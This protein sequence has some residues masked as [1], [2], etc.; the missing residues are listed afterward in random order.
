MGDDRWSRIA[1]HFH[2]AA[3]LPPAEQPA[4]L[5]S[6]CAGDQ[7]LRRE[8]ESLLAA[9]ATKAAIEGAAVAPAAEH[10]AQ[11]D[12]E[13]D[14]IGKRIDRYLI[15]GLIGK[16]G[17]GA[18]YRAVREDEFR[19]E[20]ALKL[21]KRGTD[22]EAA[23]GRFRTERQIL[24]GLNHPNITKLLD[25]GT[26]PD[27]RPYFV[28][29][30]VEGQPITNYC[31]THQLSTPERLELFRTVCAAVQYA[32]RNLVVHRDLKPANILVTSEG[33]PKLLDFG[34]A[35]I[36]HIEPAEATLDMTIPA[37]R[38][39]TPEYASPEQV[40]GEPIT[41][42][43]D[44]Y[45]LGIL[46]YE[47]LT[48]QR[49]HRLKTRTPEEFAAVI[50]ND[51]PERPSAVATRG[52]EPGLGQQL[53]KQLRGDLDNIV[54]KALQKD[55]RRRYSSVEQMEEDIRRHLEGLPVIARKDT[56][57]YRTGKFIRR[58]KLG[59]AAVTTVVAM[60]AI[61]AI[62]MTVQAR[63]IAEERN[64]ANREAEAARQVSDFLVGLFEVS[65][66]GQARGSTIT[67]RELLDRGAKKIERDLNTQPLT[68]ARMKYTVGKVLLNLGLY[69]EAAELLEGAVQIQCT[70]LGDND[71]ALMESLDRLATTY[72]E[73]GEY[74]KAEPLFRRALAIAEKIRGPEH[75]ETGSVLSNLGALGVLRNNYA[76][77]EPLLK[78][79]LEIQ[80][81]KYGP[82]HRDVADT[83]TN[84][85]VLC[86]RM[87]RQ[88]EATD[89]Y[90][91]VLALRE[92]VL[93]P[94]HPDIAQALNNLGVALWRQGQYTEAAPVLERSLALFQKVLG[95]EH[96]QVGR[97]MA[98][99][100]TLYTDQGQ[101]AKAET[102]Y[103]RSL[104]IREKALGPAHPDVAHSLNRLGRLRGKQGKYREAV[105]LY[106]R[107]LA[108]Y[109]KALGPDSMESAITRTNLANL[110]RD[111]AKYAAAEPLY[112]RALASMEKTFGPNNTNVALVL[113][114]FAQ[115]LR[116]A[117][118]AREAEPV[119]ARAKAIRETA[120]GSG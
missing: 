109:D 52:K 63:R 115:M 70:R 117:R 10:L 26:S 72:Q 42:S 51:E 19:M 49:P 14:L 57:A 97:L 5:D 20:V 2:Q 111:H 45:S 25:G 69:R 104:E 78:R 22:T 16:G 116:K 6:A 48:G 60:L 119:E 38:V 76:E 13:T 54:L 61:F 81:K 101:L 62:G 11:A 43:T 93:A 31:Q 112:R 102:L 9:D 92:K 107:A 47:L 100:A 84:L 88:K 37:M 35:K 73:Q 64:R 106:E 118:R 114:D 28:M 82:D 32:H 105:G 74:A 110:H 39:M 65:D 41:T 87:G 90:R 34:I 71:A 83:L 80:R 1:D 23:L 77:A 68:Q 89:Y 3:H 27:H 94:D 24:A 36:L 75:E 56:A 99:L 103:L 40:R 21:L 18:V 50:C 79:A 58:H 44:V 46:L 66:P 96:S 86:E 17:M 120:K 113:G 30:F 85:A 67:A 29:E 33:V 98:N 12:E 8:V 55:P 4:F 15:T 95:P 91:Q 7:E 53:R 59:F 108:T